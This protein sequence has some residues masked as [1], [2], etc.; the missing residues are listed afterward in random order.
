VPQ[1]SVTIITKDEAAH[2]AEVIKSVAWAD[3]I[4]VV[5]S[6]STDDT[7]A[8]ARGFTGR[9]IVRPWPG[10]TAQKN[11]AASIASHDW[12][13]SVDADERVTPA[14]AAE[15]RALLATTPSCPGYRIPRVTWHLQRW[16]R[17]TDWYPDYQL[18]LYDRRAGEWTGRYVH[19]A[20]AVRGV[21]G[22]LKGELQHFAFRDIADH[23]ETIDRYTTYAARQ[24]YESGRRAGVWQLALH[25]PLAF[26]RNYALRGGVRDGLAG[27]V[28]SVMNS[29]YVFLK[30]AK[31]WE[32]QRS[33]ACV[34]HEETKTTKN[35]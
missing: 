20:V 30:F 25:P 3:E 4:V 5:D 15:I 16:I 18:R 2:V 6:E 7:A 11:Y 33:A 12:I 27:F 10:Y 35:T 21:A 8:I 22:K 19:E 32:L 26:L 13:L 34:R 14:L 29:Y 28:I 24:M 31:L 9:V 17:T 1:L 23:L